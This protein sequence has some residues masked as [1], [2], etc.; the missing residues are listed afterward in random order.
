V[1][2]SGLDVCQR[3]QKFPQWSL[4][5]WDDLAFFH[6]SSS[7]SPIL[8]PAAPEPGGQGDLYL[9]LT[10]TIAIICMIS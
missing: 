2:A 10:L 3:E 4:L 7:T 9:V 6:L 8:M 5:G 1:D